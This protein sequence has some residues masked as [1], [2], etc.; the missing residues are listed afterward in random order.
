MK[1][2]VTLSMCQVL[3]VREVVAAAEEELD[4]WYG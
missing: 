4:V 3:A 1:L 2:P